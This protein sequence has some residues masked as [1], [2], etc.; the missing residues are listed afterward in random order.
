MKNTIDYLEAW[1]S[2][3]ESLGFTIEKY[4][5]IQGL[6]YFAIIFRA[7]NLDK[8]MFDASGKIS[9]TPGDKRPYDRHFVR[10]KPSRFHKLITI[11]TTA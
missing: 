9:R 8:D 4:D 7:E 5:Y 6:G 3:L 10:M 2:Y 1:R 11:K